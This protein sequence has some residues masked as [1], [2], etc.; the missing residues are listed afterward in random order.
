MPTTVQTLVGQAAC[1]PC[2]VY[3]DQTTKAIELILWCHLLHQ[4]PPESLDTVDLLREA[5]CLMC[6]L[7][8]ANLDAAL[9]AV[10][11]AIAN[12]DRSLFCTT[13]DLARAA[14]CY[15]S[16]IPVGML[17]YV[18]VALLSRLVDSGY[19]IRQQIQT[20]ES[21]GLMSEEGDPIVTEESAIGTNPAVSSSV[22]TL[23]ELAQ[24]WF[25]LFPGVTI[26]YIETAILLAAYDG[27]Y[28]QGSDPRT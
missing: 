27:A 28:G 20:D 24:C 13:T 1:Y 19:F 25:C 22:T 26:K 5:R 7:T 6:G 3:S 4:T 8:G 9:I 16:C 17:P 14:R 12:D 18:K 11:V 15:L 10:L 21:V 2:L 23:L